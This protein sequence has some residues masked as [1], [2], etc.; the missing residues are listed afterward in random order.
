MQLYLTERFL[1]NLGGMLTRNVS[2]WAVTASW[3]LL[4]R[5]PVTYTGRED[6]DESRE[7][8]NETPG[9]KPTE[10]HAAHTPSRSAGSRTAWSSN[11]GLQKI[12]IGTNGSVLPPIP[13]G[14]GGASGARGRFHLAMKSPLAQQRVEVL[15]EDAQTMIRLCGVK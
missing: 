1:R 2:P 10:V 7:E 6:G 14:G 9:I 15:V 3:R 11:Q 12:F 4:P 8:D 13:A 5:L